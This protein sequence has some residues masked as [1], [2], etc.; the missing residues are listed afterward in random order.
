MS[1]KPYKSTVAEKVNSK[2][3]SRR[4]V[5]VEVDAKL[6]LNGAT[7]IATTANENTVLVGSNLK[8]VL[9]LRVT[10]GNRLR[11]GSND[12]I[13]NACLAFDANGVTVRVLTRESNHAG[14]FAAIIRTA[15]SNDNVADVGS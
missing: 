3:E 13:Y 6:G 14:Q 9:H 4:A 2:V 11:D 10:F 12:A 5:N 7:G 15:S 1:Q 8:G